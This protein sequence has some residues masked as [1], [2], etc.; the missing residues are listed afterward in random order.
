[1]DIVS[2]PSLLG[3]PN[4]FGAPPPALQPGEIVDALVVALLD[5][6]LARLQLP[7]GTIDVRT[8]VPL[9]VGAKVRLAVNGTSA[10]LQ[11]V[12]LTDG[13][14]GR[15]ATP[16]ALVARQPGDAPARA[17]TDAN[18]AAGTGFETPAVE[19]AVSGAI[20]ASL[21]QAASSP[22]SP[23]AAD[24]LAEAMQIAAARQGGL[25]PLLA[26]LEQAVN[27][28]ALPASVAAA[29][30]QVLDLRASLARLDAAALRQALARS[31]LFLEAG[32]AA[33]LSSGTAAGMASG[34]D[35]K[36]AL[37]VLRQM[38]KSWF[39]G[40]P[41]PG[42]VG[43]PVPASAPPPPYRGAPPSAQPAVPPSLPPFALPGAMA[44]RL[45]AETDEALARHTLLQVASLPEA[46]AAG[47]PA[48]RGAQWAFEIPFATGQGGAIAQ[49]EI[50]RDGQSA[51]TAEG[52]S[53]WRV[54]F[55]LNVEPMGP[56]HALIAVAGERAAVTLWAER[57]ASAARLRAGSSL[58]AEALCGAALAPGDI[59]FRVGTP[60]APPPAAGRFLDRAS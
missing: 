40:E 44:Q 11:L 30:G 47:P 9:T 27:G 31:G 43:L 32:L 2:L 28:G 48:Q 39:D 49:F 33:S 7:D 14:S 17:E 24:A 22:L 6:G 50:S 15:T 59:Q 56:V 26:D 51:A 46:G 53:V 29:A 41:A 8:A 52:P 12:V 25:A 35:L 55:S 60:A 18:A 10:G 57:E 13:G 42:P 4:S 3:I 23:A 21:P 19:I 38:L 34:V 5:N 1:M 37:L 45:L 36:A 20:P 54:R 16:A 58:L